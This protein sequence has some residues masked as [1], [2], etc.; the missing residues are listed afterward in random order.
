MPLWVEK[1]FFRIDIEFA[2][3]LFGFVVASIFLDW[4]IWMWVFIR[5][6]DRAPF[7]F[8]WLGILAVIA[9]PFAERPLFL[10]FD[11]DWW[12]LLLLKLLETGC[13]FY[14]VLYLDMALSSWTYVALKKLGWIGS[15]GGE[16]S[17][18]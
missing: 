11:V 2:W 1:I 13:I 6:K 14:G 10:N 3:V 7:L 8:M 16:E 15:K 17:K 12:F 5:G 18:E 4:F 9:L